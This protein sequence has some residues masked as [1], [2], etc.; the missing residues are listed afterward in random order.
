MNYR[1]ISDLS[2]LTSKYAS[3]VPQSVDLIVGIPRSGMLVAS[4]IS[5]KLNLPLTDLY[6]FIRNDEL[7]RGTTR[8]YKY[9][10]LAKPQ[11]A[12]QILLVDDSIAT[13]NSMR[14][15]VAKVKEVYPGSVV[16]MAAFAQQHNVD[17]ID[18]YLD[19]V[20]KPRVFEWNIMHHHYITRACLDIDGV[21]C[22]DPTADENDDGQCYRAFLAGAKP[23]FLPSVQ[24]AHLV[25]SRLEKYR[26]ETEAWLKRHGVS[27]G[28][29]HMLNLPSAEERRRLNMHHTFKA[30]IYKEQLQ[31]VLFIESEELQARE[32][33]RLSNKPVYC[34]ATNEMY[35]PGVNL[36]ALKAVTLRKGQSLKRKIFEHLRKIFSRLPA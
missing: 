36:S 18:L 27:Y 3:K 16:T 22:V 21:L 35:V 24:V 17:A 20:E 10:E 7:K 26:P 30:R 19:I 4:I 34:T 25:T 8:T 1:S 12:K 6:A 32:I 29:L 31:A 33:M 15:A 28:K 2:A 9:H 13:G 11:D 14:E 5:L 23:L